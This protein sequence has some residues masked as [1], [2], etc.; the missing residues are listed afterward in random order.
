[1]GRRMLTLLILFFFVFE[2]LTFLK[3][4]TNPQVLREQCFNDSI[5]LI[6]G[7]F[8]LSTHKSNVDT[9]V[10]LINSPYLNLRVFYDGIKETNERKKQLIDFFPVDK[11]RYI[12]DLYNL[13]KLIVN[14]DMGNFLFSAQEFVSN[15]NIIP[16]EVLTRKFWQ[17][18]VSP[19]KILG[20]YTMESIK[21]NSIE[22]YVPG[23]INKA[24]MRNRMYPSLLA[25][26]IKADFEYGKKKLYKRFLRSA[27]RYSKDLVI[28]LLLYRLAQI[29]LEQPFVNYHRKFKKRLPFRELW[30]IKVN[31]SAELIN[32]RADYI[33]NVRVENRTATYW[34]VGL[35]FFGRFYKV[36]SKHSL[37]YTKMLRFLEQCPANMIA[38]SSLK[39]FQLS[40]FDTFF[41]T[42]IMPI[43]AMKDIPSHYHLP[44]I[45][46]DNNSIEHRNGLLSRFFSDDE[47]NTIAYSHSL[48]LVDFLQ[49][50]ADN[51]IGLLSHD[52]LDGEYSLL[53][54]AT[55][56]CALYYGKTLSEEY[57]TF[58]SIN[59]ETIIGS[60][61]LREYFTKN[62]LLEK[63][64]YTISHYDEN[65]KLD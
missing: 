9:A 10:S 42:D 56:I 31:D 59:Y 18:M 55:I 2:G 11:A 25:E 21:R 17:N 53:F 49:I 46:F 62:G 61:V 30:Q 52:L 39:Y 15:P 44:M 29:S 27:I 1:M 12:M 47:F 4:V 23:L 14:P 8:K 6:L 5:E 24:C 20:S 48:S 65:I 38:S 33:I 19:K 13:Q 36:I 22:I 51:S 54:R 32:Y 16:N 50:S 58:I 28:D 37:L 35:E 57:L 64:G 7:S 63:L 40:Y 3:L 26:I 41:Y 43:L 34:N 45:L 60:S